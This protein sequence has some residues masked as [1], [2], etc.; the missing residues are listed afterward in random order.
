MS[1]TFWILTSAGALLL[2]MLACSE[3]GRRIGIA[4]LARDPDGIEKGSGPVEA[5]IFGLL[6]LLLA[7]TFSGAATRFEERRHLIAEETNA[8]GTAW[9]RLDLLPADAQPEI[10]TLF[11]RYLD[12]RVE[13]YRDAADRDATAARLAEATTLQ[14][15]IWAKAV[16][17]S[18]RPEVS[19][20]AAMLLLPALNDLID[21]TTTRAVAMQTHPPP[22]IFLLLVGLSLVCSLLVGYVMCSTRVRSWFYLLLIAT[23]MSLTIY[24]IL[25]LEYPRFGLI[26]VDAA[27]QTLIELRE[28]MR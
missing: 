22:I 6:G 9:L 23:T 3:A 20:Q 28:Q 14:H 7:F 8:I 12:V 21:I 25:D 26:R 11:R 10:R 15:D 4:R 17:A 2:A 19:T 27:D 24:V 18:G 5:A 13:T 1:F 16:L